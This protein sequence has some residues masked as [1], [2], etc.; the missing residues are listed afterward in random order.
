VHGEVALMAA[1]RITDSLFSGQLDN[2]TES[3]LEQLAQD[4]MPGVRW[5]KPTPA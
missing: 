2:L 3:D 5:K 1:R 4:G